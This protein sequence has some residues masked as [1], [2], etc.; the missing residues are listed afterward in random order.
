LSEFE[1]HSNHNILV[2]PVPT[3]DNIIIESIDFGI[4]GALYIFSL[5]GELLYKIENINSTQI[6]LELNALSNGMYFIKVNTENRTFYK[7]II[8][9]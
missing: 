2:Y 4:I 9:D 6:E 7:K 5:N 1:K 3:S 8:K